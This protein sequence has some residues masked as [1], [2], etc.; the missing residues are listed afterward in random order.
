VTKYRSKFLYK[1]LIDDEAEFALSSGNNAANRTKLID[2]K[3]DNLCYA[4]GEGGAMTLTWTPGAAT[5]VSRIILQGINWK[6]FTVKY[7]TNVNFSDAISEAANAYTDRLYE[8]TSQAVNDIVFTITA[9]ITAG[10]EIRTGQIIVSTEIYEVASTVAC[11]I[12]SASNS[13]QIEMFRMSDGTFQKVF[14]REITNYDISYLA[15]S[16]A[17]KANFMTVFDTNKYDRVIFIPRPRDGSDQWDGKCNHY[18]IANM[19][20]DMFTRNVEYNGYDVHIQLKQA[21]GLG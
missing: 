2:G 21:S 1:N 12:L 15:V 9:P 10:Q 11:N 5:T 16:Q 14:D 18:N 4:I 8:V 3:E 7:N 6:T 20:R 19:Q 13:D 17:E